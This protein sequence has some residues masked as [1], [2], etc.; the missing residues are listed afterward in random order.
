MFFHFAQQDARSTVERE[1]GNETNG[2]C[3]SNCSGESWWV[4]LNEFGRQARAHWDYKNS[5]LLVAI[6]SRLILG[7]SQNLMNSNTIFNQTTV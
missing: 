7:K 1:C 6:H 3:V 5:K 2:K 4:F